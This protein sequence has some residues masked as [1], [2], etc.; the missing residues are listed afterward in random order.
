M[1]A[2][3]E[4]REEHRCA[5]C[6]EE[7]CFF[8]VEEAD[9]YGIQPRLQP[10]ARAQADQDQDRPILLSL[11]LPTLLYCR[12]IY[13]SILKIQKKLYV[14]LSFRNVQMYTKIKLF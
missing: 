10:Q 11:I 8:H 2:S 13:N 6:S 3:K 9:R 1:Q 4:D 12:T 7:Q 14:Y 5:L